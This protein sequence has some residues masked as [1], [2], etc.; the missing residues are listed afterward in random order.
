MRVSFR[1]KGPGLGKV[2]DDDE[3]CFLGVYWSTALDTSG[4]IARRSR[5]STDGV[6]EAF[7]TFFF[8]FECVLYSIAIRQPR[9]HDYSCRKSVQPRFR[10]SRLRRTIY[11]CKF[12]ALRSFEVVLLRSG[13]VSLLAH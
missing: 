1:V 12:R 2:V 8:H 9:L 4:S 10:R 13:H 6:Y 3:T 11:L 7:R 5:L